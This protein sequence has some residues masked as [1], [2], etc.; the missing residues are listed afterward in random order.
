[1]ACS[2]CPGGATVLGPAKSNGGEY[3]LIYI[4]DEVQII[5]FGIVTGTMYIFGTKKKEFYADYRD[6]PGLFQSEFG[7]LLRAKV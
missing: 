2:G 4:G 5:E 7:N 3:I 6:V 1:M